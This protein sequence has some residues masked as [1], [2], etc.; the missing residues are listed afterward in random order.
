[1]FDNLG[2]IVGTLTD[3]LNLRNSSNPVLSFLA[4]PLG[5]LP[6]DSE[7]DSDD[8]DWDGDNEWEAGQQERLARGPLMTSGQQGM[9]TPYPVNPQIQA[10]N[11]LRGYTYGR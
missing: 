8:D 3:P 1:M 5:V 6:K 2:G 4:D 10:A 7:G 11:M 9:H